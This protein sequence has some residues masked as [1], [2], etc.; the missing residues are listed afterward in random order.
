MLNQ[1]E[2]LLKVIQ[3]EVEK[4]VIGNAGVINLNLNHRQNFANAIVVLMLLKGRD[5]FVGII[6]NLKHI[7]RYFG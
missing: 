1:G 7:G 3:Q 6:P 5:S 2:D 4:S